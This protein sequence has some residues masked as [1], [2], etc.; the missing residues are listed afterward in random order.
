LPE[1]YGT[2]QIKVPKA[3]DYSPGQA[4]IPRA[5]REMVDSIGAG[6]G[7][8]KLLIVQAT[9]AA[10]WKAMKGDGTMDAEG[11]LQLGKAVVGVDELAPNAVGPTKI[12]EKAVTREKMSD[13]LQ[14]KRVDSLEIA[15]GASFKLQVVW[16]TPFPDTNYTATVTVRSGNNA[17]AEITIVKKTKEQIDVEVTAVKG[18][19]VYL[20]AIAIHD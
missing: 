15:A 5:F 18:G 12:N 6:L 10:A 9:G 2:P 11:N 4:D 8:G 16:A 3:S 7:G 20:D 14:T 13:F 19:Q 17:R 1:T